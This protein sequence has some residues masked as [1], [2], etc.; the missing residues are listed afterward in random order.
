V[1]GMFRSVGG[2]LGLVTMARLFSS[3][4]P[5]V[6][7]WF[8]LGGPADESMAW[9]IRHVMYFAAFTS[10]LGVILSVWIPRR[11]QP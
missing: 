4:D 6:T 2:A 9:A 10:F 11:R 1:M 7:N 3:Y 8:L 5:M